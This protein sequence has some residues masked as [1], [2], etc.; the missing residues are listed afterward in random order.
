[1]AFVQKTFLFSRIQKVPKN[2]KA[3][4]RGG[5]WESFC[6]SCDEAYNY[7]QDQTGIIHFFWRAK[8]QQIPEYKV[9]VPIIASKVSFANFFFQP[10]LRRSSKEKVVKHT[11]GNNRTNV[12][13]FDSIASSIMCKSGERG[14]EQRWLP[15]NNIISVIKPETQE[16]K[17]L[18]SNRYYYFI[19]H[20]AFFL[21]DM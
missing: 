2:S 5:D 12:T 18:T 19:N 9:F 10:V 14:N 8:T 15:S 6:G 7:S 20:Q 21:Y 13:I 3:S 1:M 4:N 11:K 16:M 17:R